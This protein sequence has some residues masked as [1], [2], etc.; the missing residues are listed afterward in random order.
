MLLKLTIPLTLLVQNILADCICQNEIG[1]ADEDPT[2]Y[3]ICLDGFDQNLFCPPG[4]RFDEKLGCEVPNRDS[5]P[6]K[7]GKKNKKNKKKEVKISPA[8]SGHIWWKFNSDSDYYGDLENW[9]L[10]NVITVTQSVPASYFM[11]VGFSEGYSG[12]QQVSKDEKIAIFSLWNKGTDSVSLVSSDPLT[13]VQEFGGE[14]TGLKS[15]RDLDWNLKDQ[16]EMRVI[17]YPAP[18]SEQK[19]HP[20][21]PDARTWRVKC[22]YRIKPFKKTKWSDWQMMA[23][24]ERTGIALL[25]PGGFYSFVEDWDRSTGANGCQSQRRAIFSNVKFNGSEAAA[26]AVFTRSTSDSEKKC[27]W[28]TFVE[29]VSDENSLVLNAGG[30]MSINNEIQQTTGNVRWEY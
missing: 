10:S 13:T 27:M 24:Y 1:C 5:N 17:G 12:I 22:E 19:T 26:N 4:T 8:N 14:G 29:Q 30:K 3:S 7:T 18:E 28:K 2:R 9:Q 6:R 25:R 23:E 15:T 20:T 11:M 21:N 16:V